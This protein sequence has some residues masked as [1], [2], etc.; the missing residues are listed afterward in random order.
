[1]D[2]LFNPDKYFGE[3]KDKISYKTPLLIVTISGILGLI[4]G[5]I[6]S[7]PMAHAVAR[8]LVE[9]GMTKEQT[10]MI[11]TFTQASTIATPLITAFVGWFIIAIILHVVSS[12]FG[13]KGN[14]S[15]TLKLSA[16]SYIPNIVLLPLN[17]YISFEMVKIL[18]SYGL[19]GLNSFEFKLTVTLL[20]IVVLIWQYIYWVF[21]VKNARELEMKK[22]SITALILLI[23]FLIP[24][25]HSLITAVR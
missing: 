25:V 19:V 9:K 11:V 15:T 13:G 18:N 6:I 21:I 3:M 22:A 10:Q 2:V 23:L 1:M 24:S 4:N 14:F 16:F 12:L 20:G 17:L 8:M 5:Y 7:K